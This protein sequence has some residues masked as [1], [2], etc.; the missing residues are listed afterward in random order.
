[1]AKKN[2]RRSAKKNLATSYFSVKKTRKQAVPLPLKEVPMKIEGVRMLRSRWV[3]E[4]KHPEKKN[5]R[6]WLGSYATQEEAAKAYQSK[7]MEHE[8]IKFQVTVK[9]EK[10]LLDD[11]EFVSALE[12]DDRDVAIKGIG[13]DDQAMEDDVIDDQAMKAVDNNDQEIVNVVKVENL[14]DDRDVRVSVVEFDDQARKVLDFT[15]KSI[16]NH[17]I[18]L[19]SKQ[20]GFTKIEGVRMRKGKWVAEIK[21]PKKKNVRIWLGCYATQ[22]EAS[23]VYQAKKMEHEK[24]KLQAIAQKEKLVDDQEVGSA[25]VE[26]NAETVSDDPNAMMEV[27]DFDG[28]RI[29]NVLKEVKAESRSD[30]CD[31]TMSVV[32]SDDQATKVVHFDDQAERSL[33]R[34]IVEQEAGDMLLQLGPILIDKYGC[35]SGEFSWIDDLSI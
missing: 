11:Q 30:D 18:S 22:E 5:V 34:G 13:N 3:A 12:S 9:K 28:E 31:V 23:K 15:A 2:S 17:A 33:S 32:D 1:M 35:L 29:V 24:L 8:A 25:Y 26:S 20:Q 21:H 14:F 4:I 7:K 10:Q 16:G 6:I 27:V 19:P